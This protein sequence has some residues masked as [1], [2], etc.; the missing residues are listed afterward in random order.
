MIH[1]IDRLVQ[2]NAVGIR[3]GHD[4]ERI[5]TTFHFIRNNYIV[6][7]IFSDVYS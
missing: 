3:R 2:L 7:N 1:P 6:Y 4:L 5:P